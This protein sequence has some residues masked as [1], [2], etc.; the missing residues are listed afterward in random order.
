MGQNQ[1]HS[2]DFTLALSGAEL[3]RIVQTV[4]LSTLG[5]KGLPCEAY[6]ERGVQHIA[7][8]VLAQLRDLKSPE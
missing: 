8:R 5:S 2:Y 3:E 6:K 1:N 4:Y 7:R